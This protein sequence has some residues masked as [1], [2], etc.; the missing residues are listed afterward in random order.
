MSILESLRK[1][2]K[3]YKFL[4]WRLVF[5]RKEDGQSNLIV[6]ATSMRSLKKEK[7]SGRNIGEVGQA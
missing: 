3:L 2:Q 7:W 1:H 6:V 5:E 4:G